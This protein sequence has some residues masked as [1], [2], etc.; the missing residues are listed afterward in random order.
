M[1]GVRRA[2]AGAEPGPARGCHR[3]WPAFGQTSRPVG[4]GGLAVFRPCRNMVGGRRGD[5]VVH[6][7]V[8]E[9]VVFFHG[10][11][12]MAEVYQASKEGSS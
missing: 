10:P 8:L 11:H 6:S 9:E 1:L 3:I 12:S 2:G 7:Q 4:Q 5:Q